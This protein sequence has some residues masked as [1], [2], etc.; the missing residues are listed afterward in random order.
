[1]SRKV[2]NNRLV[3]MDFSHVYA[4]QTFYKEAEGF[5]TVWLD[6]S[7]IQGTNCYC[8][9]LAKEELKRRIEGLGP[10]GVHFLDS[11]NYHYVSKL[12][13]EQIEEPF[14]LLVFDHHTDMQQPMFGDILS[15]GGWIKAAL[16]TNPYLNR[17]YLAGPPIKAVEESTEGLRPYGGRLVWISSRDMEDRGIWER[18]F[19]KKD[20][21][22][23]QSPR[24]P[25][26]I[27]V[28]KDVLGEKDARTNWDQG[29]TSLETVLDGIRAAHLCRRIIG[30]DVCGE[31]PEGGEAG[32]RADVACIND[33][34]NLLLCCVG[35][36]VL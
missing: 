4:A 34:T 10:G 3:V 27:S 8:D 12:W 32:E 11:G 1:M 22:N 28:D 31:N 15:C 33:R 30:M 23:T 16:D 18:L 29:E 26:Y 35:K 24:H 13:L 7:G 36:E 19:G 21:R 2:D 25:L 5:E 20:D 9:E 6:V 14:D 17:V